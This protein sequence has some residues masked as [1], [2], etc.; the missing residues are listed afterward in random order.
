VSVLKTNVRKK[1]YLHHLFS[2]I[3]GNLNFH[4]SNFHHIQS[5]II[6]KNRKKRKR[7]KKNKLKKNHKKSYLSLP[8]VVIFLLFNLFIAIK[9][10]E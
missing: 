1:R 9:N 5:V 3:E 8:L 4:I 7:I 2:K 6:T 10:Y